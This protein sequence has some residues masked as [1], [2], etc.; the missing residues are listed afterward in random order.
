M[1][2]KGDPRGREVPSKSC[3]PHHPHPTSLDQ[4]ACNRACYSTHLCRREP[5]GVDFLTPPSHTSLAA[6]ISQ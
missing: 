1:Q 2:E 5:S 6:E 3:W 4:S